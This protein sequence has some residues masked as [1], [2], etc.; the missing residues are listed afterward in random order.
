MFHLNILELVVNMKHR[1]QIN[2]PKC[3]FRNA[4]SIV[5]FIKVLAF[6]PVHR[7]GNKAEHIF[8]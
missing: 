8:P 3:V 5:R 6:S 7:K 1:V 4:K 2:P